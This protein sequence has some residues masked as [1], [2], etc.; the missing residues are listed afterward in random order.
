M[1]QTIEALQ[2]VPLFRDAGFTRPQFMLL[3]KKLLARRFGDG[4]YLI[5]QVPF[6]HRGVSAM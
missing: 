5:T 3:S 4:E 2:K 1:D 6:S